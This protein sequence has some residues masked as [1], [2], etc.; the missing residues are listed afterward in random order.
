[1]MSFSVI[2]RAGYYA[3]ANNYPGYE[4]QDLNVYSAYTG[5]DRTLV[6]LAEFLRPG[7]TDALADRLG[8]P[9]TGSSTGD[10]TDFA[11]HELTDGVT[12]IRYMA[13]SFLAAESNPA[14]QVLGRV[15]GKGVMG[16]L[17]NRTAKIMFIGDV[18]GIE[19]VPQPF[20]Q[21]L[22]RWGF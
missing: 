16:L 4:A 7:Q 6:I 10:V 12:T 21:N 20:V 22:V 13:G 5:C 18:N 17:T 15:D 8:I 14:I 9:L 1:M 11:P 19:Q 3:D 2:I